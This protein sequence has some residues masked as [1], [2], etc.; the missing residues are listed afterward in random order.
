MADRMKR[1]L[2]EERREYGGDTLDETSLPNDPLELFST[3]LDQAFESGNPDPTAMILSTVERNGQPSSRIVLLKK[4]EDGKFVFFT[5]YH[6]RKAREIRARPRVAALFYWP[7]LNRQVKVTGT[8]GPVD[9]AD[10]DHY[11]NKR[12]YESRIS[13]WA[14]PQSE[15]IPNRQYLEKEFEKYRKRYRDPENVPRPAY[16]G[17]Y[18]IYPARIE[19]WQG[20]RRRLHDRIEYTKKEER[21]SMARLAP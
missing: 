12:P 16:W 8:A 17:G 10:S 19:F 6:S 18:A 14:S 3:W 7:E 5:N 13:A 9:D 21:W 20:V 2:E 4:V 1:D 15:E 11:F